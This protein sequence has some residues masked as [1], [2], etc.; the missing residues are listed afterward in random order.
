M[1]CDVGHVTSYL[2]TAKVRIFLHNVAF[3]V[4]KSLWSALFPCKKGAALFP[5]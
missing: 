4:A 2:D 5:D 3:P 1:D